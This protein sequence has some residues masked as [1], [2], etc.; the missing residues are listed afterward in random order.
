MIQV[1]IKDLEIIHYDVSVKWPTTLLLFELQSPI[2]VLKW[3]SA[4][5]QR[6]CKARLQEFIQGK[7]MMG[8][9]Q[10][11]TCLQLNQTGGQWRG[12]CGWGGHS[13]VGKRHGREG[14][15]WMGW[16]LHWTLWPISRLLPLPRGRG[17]MSP[18]HEELVVAVQGTLAIM[19][20]IFGA[21][22]TLCFGH[23]RTGLSIRVNKKKVIQAL[24]ILQIKILCWWRSGFGIQ[25][26]KRCYFPVMK[27]IGGK[28]RFIMAL[29]LFTSIT[30]NMFFRV[31]F[32]RGN[33]VIAICK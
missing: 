14:W 12:E 23:L 1:Y 17:Q 25:V 5:L 16:D 19:A 33:G 30:E 6:C 13:R 26:K 15:V 31:S 29:T 10:G 27:F 7:S 20:V 9:L 11:C 3:C 2:V 24:V 8:Q 28:R 22:A 18:S 4:L 32:A 21:M